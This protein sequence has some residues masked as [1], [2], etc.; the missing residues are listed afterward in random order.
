[1]QVVNLNY[2]YLYVSKLKSGVNKFVV[3][4][5][6]KIYNVELNK[7]ALS[8]HVT[9]WNYTKEN[10]SR[11]EPQSEHHFG[12]YV[13]NNILLDRKFFENYEIIKQAKEVVRRYKCCLAI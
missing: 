10:V 6:R 7:T 9:F 4:F 13:K 8:C 11:Y 3:K 12:L 2:D 1:M 5:G